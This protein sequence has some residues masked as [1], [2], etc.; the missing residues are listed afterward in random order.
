MCGLTAFASSCSTLRGG[1]RLR[2]RNYRR[3]SSA[4]AGQ[5][6][7]VGGSRAGQR[8]AA[9]RGRLV[10]HEDRTVP[11]G[12]GPSRQARGGSGGIP[13]RRSTSITITRPFNARA[14]AAPTDTPRAGAFSCA[15]RR[16]PGRSCRAR[17]RSCRRWPGGLP[18]AG[19]R[20]RTCGGCLALYDGRRS[21]WRGR[22]FDAGIQAA[23]QGHP[24]RR[25]FLVRVEHDPAVGAGRRLS[26]QRSRARL[27][28]VVLSVE[29]PAR[30]MSC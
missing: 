3:R 24:V 25:R 6:Q 23:L 28:V 26:D 13:S 27:A 18:A 5:R 22:G 11:E 2:L 21:A 19:H 7:G 14:P 29:Q 8:R 30:T 9:A 20:Q 16:P 1:G 17:R 4:P 15:T 10:Q 12:R